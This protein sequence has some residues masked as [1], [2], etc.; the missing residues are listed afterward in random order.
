MDYYIYGFRG[1]YAAGIPD[2]WIFYSY[3]E[4]D[5]MIYAS[6]R[7]TPPKTPTTTPKNKL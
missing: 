1:E 3:G 2:M 4:H 7:T 6:T 5:V